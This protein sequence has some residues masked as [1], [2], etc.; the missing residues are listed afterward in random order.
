MKRKTTQYG[1]HIIPSSILG[2][3]LTRMRRMFLKGDDLCL[4]HCYLLLFAGRGKDG[5]RLNLRRALAMGNIMGMSD[6]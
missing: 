4:R 3:R 5:N 2:I 6:M 1:I